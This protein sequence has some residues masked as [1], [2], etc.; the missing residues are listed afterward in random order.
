[1]Q[2]KPVVQYQLFP[3]KL[4]E[5]TFEPLLYNKVSRLVAEIAQ[6]ALRRSEKD[7]SEAVDALCEFCK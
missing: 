2:E 4:N 7:E 3:F 6:A 5:E 1:M